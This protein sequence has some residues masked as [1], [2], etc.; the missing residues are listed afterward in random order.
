MRERVGGE[1]EN[2]PLLGLWDTD[3]IIFQMFLDISFLCKL[4]NSNIN[5]SSNDDQ[6]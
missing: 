6:L 5:H 4:Q 2:S 3:F 1:V